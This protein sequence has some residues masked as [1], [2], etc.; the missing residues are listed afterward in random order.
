MAGSKGKRLKQYV[1]GC[2]LLT[3]F[4]IVVL[5]VLTTSV[6]LGYR[7]AFKVRDELER[8]HDTQAEFTPPAAGTIPAD[9]MQRFL[10]VREELLPLCEKVSAHQR[11]FARMHR[12][13]EAERPPVGALLGDVFQ[14]ARSVIR[15][16]RDYGEYV[17]VRN[18]ALLAEDMG[19]GEYTWIY[20]VAYYAWLGHEPVQAVTGR[21]GPHVFRDRVFPQVEEMIRRHVAEVGEREG[22]AAWRS[23]LEALERFPERVPF[24]EGLPPE[25]EGSLEPHRNQLERLACPE[26]GE[27]DVVLTV[28]SGFGYDH[29]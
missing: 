9:R 15:L 5:A 26:A 10:T 28:K 23:E 24:Q 2:G 1:I 14:A 7:K 27:L 12:Q 6:F 13:G 22:V 18:E 8:L 29:R 25:I 17:T 4:V 11:R 16:G 20:V 21:A 3:L 19:L